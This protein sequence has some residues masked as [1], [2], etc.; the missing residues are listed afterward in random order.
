M[1][2]PFFLTLRKMG[3]PV[4][5]GD[6]LGFLGVLQAGLASNDPDAFY[7]LARMSL[8]KDERQFDR[9]DRAFAEAFAGLEALPDA[10][11]LQ[12]LDI[13]LDWLEAAMARHFTAEE[14]AAVQAMGGLDALMQALRDRLAEQKG[15]HAGG[16]KWVGTGGTS[17]FGHGG[18]N[19]EGVRIGGPGGQRRAVKVWEARAFRDLDADADLAPRNLKLALR[20]LRRWARTGPQVLD[21]KATVE[22]T[23]RQGWLDVRETRARQ[24]AVNLLLFLDIG[25]SM[26]DHIH[27]T[28]ALFGA[29][30]SEFHRLTVFY[31]HNCLYETLWTDAPR[32][33][34]Q[35]TQDVLRRFG[36]QT[37]AIFVGDA[38]MS[39]YEVAAKGGSVEH[40]N[41]EPG[42]VW[43]RRARAAWPR[44]MWINPAPESGWRFTQSTGMIG[45][46]FDGKMVPLTLNGLTRGLKEI[47]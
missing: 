19:P 14:R 28:S 26:D 44:S 43:L 33:Q 47:T 22:A 42:E 29:A 39:P 46:I 24:N 36:P 15:R 34:S 37:R 30:R 32:S 27:A 11:V 20:S 12:A 16:S 9:F 8:V 45:D 2:Q 25:G 18:Y 21:L 13:P 4:G 1:F 6:Y 7:H 35:P 23:A 10:A 38:A 40:W 5:L 41:P 31:F 3:L 17:P